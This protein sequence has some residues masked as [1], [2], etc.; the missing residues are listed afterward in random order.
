MFQGRIVVIDDDPESLER[1]R[2]F[3]TRRRFEV[4][5][6]Q[7]GEDAL[8]LIRAIRPHLVLLDICLPGIDGVETLQEIRRFDNTVGVI[9]MARYEDDE[10]GRKSLELGASDYMTKPIDYKYL[11]ISV[12]QKLHSM[13]G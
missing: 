1:I 2:Q 8:H 9:M 7:T 6:A 5:T 4:H 3:L 10:K 12:V 11:E 13:I